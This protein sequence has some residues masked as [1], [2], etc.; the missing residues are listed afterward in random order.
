MTAIAPLEG[1]LSVGQ[2]ARSL[3]VSSQYVDRLARSGRL[4]YCAT[5]L[6][7][8]FSEAEIERIRRERE[9]KDPR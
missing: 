9:A 2:A 8:L 3:G 6:G 7:R 4:A 1:M 5:P